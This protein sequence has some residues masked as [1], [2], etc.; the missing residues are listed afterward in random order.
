[1]K[2]VKLSFIVTAWYF[3]IYEIAFYARDLT[4][5]FLYVE[6]MSLIKLGKQLMAG[7]LS[8]YACLETMPGC[9]LGFNCVSD[10]S[11]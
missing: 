8:V 4:T 11:I 6:F 2:V 3:S 9:T 10:L 7:Q 5:A 1:M